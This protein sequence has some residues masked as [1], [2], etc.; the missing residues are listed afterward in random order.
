[1]YIMFDLND[2]DFFRTEID[3]IRRITLDYLRMSIVLTNPDATYVKHFE[4]EEEANKYFK[5]TRT[6]LS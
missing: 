3:Y 4:N 5:S 2:R 6:L 1:M